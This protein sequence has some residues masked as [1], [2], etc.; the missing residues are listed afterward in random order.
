MKETKYFLVPAPGYYGDVA[1]VLSS[2]RTLAAARKAETQS[3]V[4]RIGNKKKGEKWLRVYE[5]TYPV[6]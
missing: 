4:V 2:H 3:S 1:W 6:A 5:E